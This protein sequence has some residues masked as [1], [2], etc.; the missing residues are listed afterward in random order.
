MELKPGRFVRYNGVVP[1]TAIHVTRTSAP[2]EK[3]AGA[4]GDVSTQRFPQQPPVEIRSSGDAGIFYATDPR[5]NLSAPNSD[6]NHSIPC[7]QIVDWPALKYRVWQDDISLRAYSDHGLPQAREITHLS[8]MK[9][10]AM[11]LYT[12]HVFKLSKHRDIARMMASRP[13]RSRAQ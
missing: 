13:S 3:R 7:C 12:E 5:Q 6:A 4:D 1:G 2:V 10:N 8:E 9:Y 11:T